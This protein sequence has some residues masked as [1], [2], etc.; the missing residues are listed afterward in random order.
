MS[1]EV[2]GLKFLRFFVKMRKLSDMNIIWWLHRPYKPALFRH[3]AL[4]VGFALRQEP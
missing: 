3:S 2:V 1:L 4:T